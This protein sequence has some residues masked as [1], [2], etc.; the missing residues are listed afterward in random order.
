MARL[1]QLARPHSGNDRFAGAS[2]ICRRH[3]AQRDVKPPAISPAAAAAA[4]AEM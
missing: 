1:I 4:A 3:T 2:S